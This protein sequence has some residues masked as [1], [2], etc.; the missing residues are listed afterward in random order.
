MRR[1]RRAFLVRARRQE[2]LLVY[3]K[4]ARKRTLAAARRR[5]RRTERRRGKRS[6]HHPMRG[7]IH[8]SS[9]A[10][11][12][13]CPRQQYQ[14]TAQYERFFFTQTNDFRGLIAS[15]N[16]VRVLVHPESM[17]HRTSGTLTSISKYSISYRFIT[18]SSWLPL[19]PA[20]GRTV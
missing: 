9:R 3:A 12:L 1:S 16:P 13:L 20:C 4:H 6:K 11:I 14:T 2:S 10:S 18:A 5:R 19:A 8:R 7:C 17:S 15:E